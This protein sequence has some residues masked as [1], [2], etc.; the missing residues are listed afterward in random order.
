MQYFFN[1]LFLTQDETRPQATSMLVR[2]G[3][4][5]ALDEP[6][7]PDAQ[8]IDLQGKT[9]LPGF[10]DAHIHVWKVGDLLTAMLDLRGVP[11]IQSM[12]EKLAAF[13]RNNPDAPWILARGFNEAIFP[14][15]RMPNRFDLDAVLPDRP[16]QIIRTCA[17]IAVL[18]SKALE[19]CGIQANTPVPDG[20][21]IRLDDAGEP[22]GIIS[23][24]ALGLAKAHI[25]E[26]DAAAYRRMISAAQDALLAAGITAASDPAVTPE[27]LAVYRQMNEEGALKIR[28]N[29]FPI[30]VPDG[31]STAYPLPELF[32]SPFL[33]VNTVKFFADGGI[34]GKTAAVK[35]PYKNTDEHGVLRLNTEWF[36]AL[37]RESL[38]AGFGVATHAIGDR[39]IEQVLDVYAA[40]H[41]ECPGRF[42]I[43]HLGL[44]EPRHLARMRDMGI[45]CVSQPIFIQELGIN[46][47]NYLPDD[48]LNRI[49]PY[50]SMLDA[51]VAL[52]F[53]SDAPVVRDFQPLSGIRCATDRRDASGTA[54][55]PHEAITREAA[56]TA[57]TR[58]AA[59]A[60]G[61][62][63]TG[64]LAPGRFADFVAVEGESAILGVWVG[65]KQAK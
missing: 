12:Q 46:F 38:A 33:T 44:P 22:T 39:A 13:A 31:A 53:S 55:A 5:V 32:D 17:H 19:I 21:E 26:P 51:G 42:R 3:V 18:N 49:Y 56:I 60:N 30:R 47:R 37:A 59:Q 57:Y 2:D 62:D 45:Y 15:G 27:L 6:P 50:R 52:A 28:I 9:I 40:L 65:G 36:T 1:G 43:E 4:I 14:D 16:C 61:S 54:I 58:T 64:V 63:K 24:T 10:I 23:E 25:P 11:D 34:S 35:Q 8:H 48:Y 20:G 7:P 41:A 29:A